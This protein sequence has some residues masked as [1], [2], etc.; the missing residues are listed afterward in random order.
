MQTFI[1]E[2]STRLLKNHPDDLSQVCVVLPGR[3]AGLYLKKALATSAGKTLWSPDVFS[4]EDF[5]SHISDFIPIDQTELL[6]ELFE[7]HKQIE[8]GQAQDFGSFSRLGQMM[9]A[10]FNEID[11]HLVDAS[12]LFDYLSEVKLIEKWN[13]DGT[14]LTPTEQN[15]ISF[16]RSLNNYYQQLREK[17]EKNKNAYQGLIYRRVAEGIETSAPKLAWTKIYF[18]GFNALTRAEQKIISFLKNSQIA[19][20]IW[21][22]DEY[23]LTDKNQEAGEFLRKQIQLGGIKGNEEVSHNFKVSEKKIFIYGTPGM[24]GQAEAAG[25]IIQRYANNSNP[26][27]DSSDTN[28]KNTALVLADENLLIPVLNSLPEA[29]GEFNITMG[30]PFKLTPAYTF[31]VFLFRLYENAARYSATTSGGERGFYHRDILRLLQHSLLNQLS[32]ISDLLAKIKNKKQVFYTPDE[33]LDFTDQSGI[34]NDELIHTIFA[35][36]NPAPGEALLIA[37]KTIRLLEEHIQSQNKNQKLNEEASLLLEYLFHVSILIKRISELHEKYRS[38]DTL[39]TLRDLFRQLSASARLPFTGEP[40]RGIQIMGMLETRTL[41]FERVILL[42]ANEGT[43]PRASVAHSLIPFDIQTEMGLPTHQQK[44]AVFAYHFY[45]LLQRAGEVHLIY[46][47][48]DA[49]SGGGEKSRF[50]YQILN[51]LRQ[52][53]P[54]IQ[55]IETSE[56]VPPPQMAAPQP[57]VVEKTEPVYQS[58]LQKSAAGL[59]PTSL[60]QYRRCPL[61]F[62]FKNVAGIRENDEVEENLEFKTIGSIVHQVLEDLFTPFVKKT[63]QPADIEKMK[64]E[65]QKYIESALA[66][67]YAHGQVKYGKNRLIYEVIKNYINAYLNFELDELAAL[68]K[69]KGTL[70][71]IGLEQRLQSENMAG[72]LGMAEENPVILKGVIDRLDL[73]NDTLRIIDYKTGKVENPSELQIAN[74]EDLDDGHKNDKVFQVLMYAWL[75]RREMQMPGKKTEG[76]VISLPKLT[77]KFIKFGVKENSRA[78]PE[79]NIDEEKLEHFEQY[80]LEMLS[81]MLDPATPFVQTTRIETCRLC[82]FKSLCK[83]T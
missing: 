20:L 21:D 80:L 38:I 50:I 41:D 14:P 37:E 16:F 12:V 58:L 62:Y 42:S 13:P 47:N 63:I 3:R 71:I 19:E 46:D 65:S 44:T 43:L 40:L 69:N 34:N 64:G 56:A 30:Y 72:E 78:T 9:L 33:I 25:K 28:P 81:K 70:Q 6:F 36:I 10:D 48:N 24:V 1:N 4:I 59:A 15:Y 8:Q 77:N 83:R 2:L 54:K 49:K 79:E 76:G 31:V 52:Y 75:C 27:S 17:L 29:T 68:S 18:A 26:G 51:E 7:I 22:A 45:R 60:N 82:D 53:N 11:L 23:Y 66:S 73:W 55:I 61:Q 74:W 35:A 32:G 39:K 57:I 67:H 5:L